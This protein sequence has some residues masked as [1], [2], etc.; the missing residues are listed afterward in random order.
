MRSFLIALT[1]AAALPAGGRLWAASADAIIPIPTAEQHGMARPWYT[2]VQLNYGRGR[3]RD[4]VLHEGVLYV[5]TD[6]ATITAL[7][8]ETGH[9]LWSKMIGRPEH[10]SMTPNVSSNLLATVNGS[11]LFV[12][13]RYTGEVLFETQVDG[14]PGAG[15]GL[16]EKFAYVPMVGG[17]I[18]AY[19]LEPLTDPIKE[20]GKVKKDMTPEEKAADKANRRE[21]LR[22]R[23][24]YIPP[25]FCQSAGRALVQPLVTLQNR[26]EEF[27]VW[28]TDRGI[29]SFA[30]IDRRDPTALTV[31][32]ELKTDAD[33]VSRPAYLPPD[34]HVHGDMAVIYAAS[35]NGRVYAMSGEERRVAMEVSRCRAGARFARRNR[36]SRLH[37]HPA[38]RHVLPGTPRAASNIGA[39]R[40]LCASLPQANSGYMPRGEA[41]QPVLA[42][43]DAHRLDII[44]GQCRPSR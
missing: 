6:R 26:Q 32:H 40:K 20:L 10:P 15:P 44:P 1:L 33:I 27:V 18:A 31:K 28:P 2:Q 8:A 11:R 22:L 4:L 21:N 9:Q 39:A 30:R 38:W 13:N 42:A 37:L 43:R 41:G 12:C 16:S 23:Q 34:P 36:K 19:R 14:S 24:E 3:V 7:D 5:Q 29:V 25:V 35:H 17:M